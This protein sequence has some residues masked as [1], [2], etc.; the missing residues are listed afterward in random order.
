MLLHHYGQVFNHSNIPVWPKGDWLTVAAMDDAVLHATLI[1]SALHI[2]LLLKKKISPD[3]LRHYSHITKILSNRF[4]DPTKSQTDATILTVACLTLMEILNASPLK[5]EPHVKALEHL[6]ARRGGV[7]SLGLKG[8]IKRKVLWADLSSAIAQ[9][10]PPR[11]KHEPTPWYPNISPIDM[12]NSDLCNEARRLANETR[13]P[14]ETSQ[15]F[16]H[17][18]C[19]SYAIS[20]INRSENPTDNLALSDYFY[21][22]EWKAYDFYSRAFK[23]AS[24]PSPNEPPSLYTPLY[25]ASCVAIIMYSNIALRE[26]PIQAGMFA[27]FISSLLQL[28]DGVDLEAVSRKYPLMLCWVLAIGG[29]VSYERPERQQYVQLFSRFCKSQG[30][31][32]WDT[33]K[34]CF[35]DSVYVTPLYVSEFRDFWNDVEEEWILDGLS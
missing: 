1:V 26:I 4:N 8:M 19:L 31:G 33:V 2:G 7:D 28:L 29:I 18:Q 25:L 12:S 23:N 15:I 10:I 9:Q 32:D 6:T 35:L 24:S 22:C 21:D 11:F 5:A 16:D 34:T 30:Y 14:V 13:N 27:P 17:L 3:A 20:L